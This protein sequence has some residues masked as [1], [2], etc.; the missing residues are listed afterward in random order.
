[1]LDRDSEHSLQRLW[2]Y[3]R[4]STTYAYSLHIQH[5]LLPARKF[6][7]KYEAKVIVSL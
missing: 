5:I 6:I 1:M 3:F 4:K 7:S 2:E